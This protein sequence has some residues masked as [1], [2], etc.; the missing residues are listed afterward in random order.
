[1]NQSH[2]ARACLAFGSLLNRRSATAGDLP[3][4]A[5]LRF[6]TLLMLPAR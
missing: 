4:L 1:M 3:L 6:S 5:T 2:I